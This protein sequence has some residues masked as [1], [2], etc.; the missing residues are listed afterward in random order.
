VDNDTLIQLKTG[1]RTFYTIQ[2]EVRLMQKQ[3][4]SKNGVALKAW[5][6]KVKSKVAAKK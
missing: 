6:K 5:V 3:P 2:K 4:S 1:I